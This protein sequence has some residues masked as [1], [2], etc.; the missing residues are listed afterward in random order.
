MV[1]TS[2]QQAALNA[3][4][5]FLREPD[6]H[7]F[8][9]RGYAGSGKTTIIRHILPLAEAIGKKC[10]LLAPTGR[11]AKML[12]TKTGC[13]ASTIHKCI[14]AFS[15]LVTTQKN[16]K[17]EA[18]IS[19]ENK[20]A[21]DLQ[22]HF[23][24]RTVRDDIHP[25]QQVY[26]VDEASMV[27]SRLQIGELLRFGSG[28]L[29]DDLLTFVRPH[30]GGKV[31]FVGDPAQLPPVGENYSAVLDESYFKEKSLQVRIAELTEVVRQRAGSA[32]L[33]N[34]M[35]VRDLLGSEQKNELDFERK[36]GEVADITP[37]GIIS[38]FHDLCPVPEIN[39]TVIIAYSN[40]LVKNYN[41]ALR[42]QYYP[43]ATHV[44]PGDVLQVVKNTVCST[45]GD[46]LFNGDFVKV[47]EVEEETES[48]A[49]PVMMDVN[50]E[51]KRVHVRLEFRD[52]MLMDEEGRTFRCKIIDTLLDSPERDLNHA[53][54]I[55]LYINFRRRH[56]K[57][58][59]DNPL[60]AETLQ[61]DPYF[62]ALHVKYGY[63]I[64]A[65]KAQG[66]EWETAFV[67]YSG[68][69]ALK[70]M[71]L[72][73]CYTATTRA[74]QALYGVNM[75]HITPLSSLQIVPILRY[76]KPAK[77]AFSFAA[78][79]TDLLPQSASPA[80]RCKCVCA[81]ANLERHGLRL[82]QVKML[83][84]VDRYTIDT[85]D[86]V[87]QFDCQYNG[88]GL[89]TD[90]RPLKVY[91]DADFIVALLAD[92]SEMTYAV[93]YTPA[94]LPLARLYARMESLCDELQII[95][96][97]IVEKQNQYHVVYHL[98]T[99]GRFSQITFYFNRT[100]AITYGQPQS[101]MGTEDVLLTALVNKLS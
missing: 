33:Q 9:L 61:A 31:I 26:I 11:A 2:Q 89:Y 6:S 57:L 40:A 94:T 37:T 29:L 84:Y 10:T 42:K 45:L 99:S 101:D 56:P 20:K 27:G 36:D 72:R 52:V 66:G 97:N 62:N 24:L 21:D 81:K 1:L 25:E 48:Q 80:Q 73:W 87:E 41:D 23:A 91:A 85:P 69:T 78:A 95:I 46:T 82:V 96:T 86:G 63:A 88:A 98:K 55:A 47:M 13:E 60:F 68:Q 65:H 76:T 50:G 93:E 19:D 100:G 14:Y 16:E 59:P 75:P 83:Q 30:L 79:E 51:R 49:A 43:E 71:P 32:I 17:D 35:K 70:E 44:M 34:A 54:T 67:D 64:T 74:S 90:Y 38:L 8:I 18:E 4:A 77:D 39:K 15:R 5:T 53:Q 22:L 28:V 92:E 7:I 3:I 12:K 58:T